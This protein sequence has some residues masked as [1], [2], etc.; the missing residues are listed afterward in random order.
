[1]NGA[2]LVSPPLPLREFLKKCPNIFK[3][4]DRVGKTTNACGFHVNVSIQGKASDIDL[5]KLVLFI[6]E[7][8]IYSMFKK[9]ATSKY[10]RPAKEL[11]QYILSEDIT[12]TPQNMDGIV[13]INS[14]N[15]ELRSSLE[16]LLSKDFGI[17]PGK[18]KQGYI[19]FRYMGGANYHKKWYRIQHVI[20]SYIFA[21]KLAANSNYR[22]DE[23]K[24]KLS[25]LLN[26]EV[27]RQRTLIQETK[28]WVAAVKPFL[29]YFKLD[30]SKIQRY[31]NAIYIYITGDRKD[32]LRAEA[33][34]VS[35]TEKGID[36]N[37]N[38]PYLRIALE[39]HPPIEFF[40]KQKYI[41]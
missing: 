33:S 11:I 5:V 10:A 3:A 37:N 6:D 8:L 34:L 36:I 25:S 7:P 24:E 26:Q 14:I 1:M 27:E 2:E 17:N 20:G 21:L 39:Q 15:T 40:T 18:L 12:L 35:V 16:T 41:S 30:L 23:Y 19:E 22:K 28:P 31:P 4:I 9:R 13:D 32:R 29:K 38:I